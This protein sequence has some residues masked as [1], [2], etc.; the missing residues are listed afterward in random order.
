VDQ[1]YFNRPISKRALEISDITD[2]IREIWRDREGPFENI[3][4]IMSYLIPFVPGLGWTVFAL[5]TGASYLGWGMG[6]FGGALDKA[7]GLEPGTHLSIT[8]PSDIEIGLKNVFRQLASSANEDE[9]KK[10]AFAGA[11]FKLIG[12]VPKLARFIFEAIKFLLLAFGLTKLGDMYSIKDTVTNIVDETQ[13]K[14][15]GGASGLLSEEQAGGLIELIKDPT[16]L[17][18]PFIG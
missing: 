12:A 1:H 14:D 18:K 2:K 6:D 10:V 9:I 17:I 7:M 11:F 13:K 4:R 5:E 16:K 8:G 3:F 15:N